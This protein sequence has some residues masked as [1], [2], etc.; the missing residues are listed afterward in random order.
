MSL[1]WWA[2]GRKTLLTSHASHSSKRKLTGKPEGK[3]I[4]RTL[5]LTLY[6]KHYNLDHGAQASEKEKWPAA[7]DR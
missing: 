1:E 6:N 5:R 2:D 7:A 3:S 4:L